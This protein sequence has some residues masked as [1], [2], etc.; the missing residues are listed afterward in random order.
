MSI[1][2]KRLLLAITV[3][4]GLLASTITYLGVRQYA[5][6]RHYD[7]VVSRSER[8]VFQFTGIREYVTEAVLQGA[9]LD[10]DRVVAEFN[11]LNG[12]I[13]AILDDILIPDEYKLAFISQVDLSGI[14]LDLRKMQTCQG[15]A[16]GELARDLVSRMREVSNRL[17]RFGGIVSHHAH[18]ELVGFQLFVIGSLAFIVFFSLLAAFYVR[19]VLVAPLA[20]C[21][22]QASEIVR[23]ERHELDLPDGLIEFRHISQ[24]MNGLLESQR[25][26][27]RRLDRH[28]RIVKALHAVEEAVERARRPDELY[29]KVCR[30]MLSNPDYC[31][32][33]IGI[34]DPGH[35]GLMPVAA[36]GCTSMA[37]RECDECVAL[38]LTEA[39]EKGLRSNPAEQAIQKREPVVVRDILRDVPTGKLKRTPFFQGTASCAAFPLKAGDTLYG[40]M[41][42]YAA[43]ETCF[44]ESEKAILESMA[45]GIARRASILAAEKRFED[46]SSKMRDILDGFPDF[47]FVLDRDGA[48]LDVNSSCLSAMGKGRDEVAGTDVRKLLLCEEATVTAL[49]Q[50]LRDR[51]PFSCECG[52]KGFAGAAFR[53]THSPGGTWDGGGVSVLVARDITREE[54]L[55][56]IARKAFRLAA[57]GMVAEVAAGEVNGLINGIINYAQ[58]LLDQTR[59]GEAGSDPV[60]LEK[61]VV[62]GEKISGIINRFLEL[63][64]EGEPRDALVGGLA[65]VGDVVSNALAFAA[66]LMKRDGIEVSLSMGGDLPS[67]LCGFRELL[68]AFTFLL[69]G[70]RESVNRAL[71]RDSAERRISVVSESF[72]TEG[73]HYVRLLISHPAPE[74]SQGGHAT[75]DPVL[76]GIEL[77]RGVISECRGAAVSRRLDP[78]THVVQVAI[79]VPAASS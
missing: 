20:S 25:E 33:W 56:E 66:P 65:K 8:L 5:L 37:E 52:L 69:Q 72:K 48:V 74:P 60:F 45:R 63:S 24:C 10:I 71:S 79:E 39:E 32:V 76:Y 3:L 58:L 50:A 30:A 51:M 42:V 53:I 15:T 73:R 38:L 43:D 78:V 47:V 49:I 16:C 35:E 46:E 29:K 14:L 27:N 75:D 62:E 40:V 36:D 17:S 55:R 54:E 67:A 44:D 59:E 28:D 34:F 68:L 26:T 4:L 23:G 57:S 11:D 2:R 19:K 12:Q 70:A 41:S 77:C 1:V 22:R 7:V 18:R 64:R 13:T 21:A 9:P 31:F 6:S 61:I